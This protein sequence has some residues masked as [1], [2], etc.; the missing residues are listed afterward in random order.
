MVNPMLIIA[1]VLI[2][3]IIVGIVIYSTNKKGGK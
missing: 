2:I 3:G 1:A